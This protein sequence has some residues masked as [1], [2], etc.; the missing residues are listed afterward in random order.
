MKRAQAVGA[1]ASFLVMS[2]IVMQSSQ[3]A[4]SAA[5][6]NTGNSWAAGTVAITDNDAGSALFNVSGLVPGDTQ[7][8]CIAVT[9]NGSEAAAVKLYARIDGGT[10]LGDYLNLQVT[11]GTGGDA[12]CTGFTAGENVYTGTLS[13]MA[14]TNTSFATGA[15]TWAPTGPAQTATYRL[16]YTLQDDNNAQG[17]NVQSTFTWEAQNT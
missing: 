14:S 10:G 6:E 11:R 4:F 15:G 16:T 13:N 1:A 7:T 8:K 9:Y 17:K 2:A 12:S 3:A 5:T